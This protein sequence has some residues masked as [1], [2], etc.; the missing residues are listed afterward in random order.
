MKYLL[1]PSLILLLVG[2]MA[3]NKKS[4]DLYQ[5]SAFKI[6]ET[7]RLADQDADLTLFKI[8]DSRCPTQVECVWA[9]VA[10]AYFLYEK[11]GQDTI[12]LS[13]TD[14][15]AVQTKTQVEHNGYRYRMIEVTPYPE[16]PE[17]IKPE[18]YRVRIEITKL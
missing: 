9:G 8:D 7:K 13:T 4:L 2:S 16:T 6:G 12:K 10:T 18:D 3:C 17:S 11:N 5:D 14:Y 15:E 1:F